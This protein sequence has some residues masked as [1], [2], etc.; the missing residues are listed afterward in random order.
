MKGEGKSKKKKKKEE[1]QARED[2]RANEAK[3]T[4]QVF[5]PC[6]TSERISVEELGILI[7]E[8]LASLTTIP[9]TCMHVC[10][11]VRVHAR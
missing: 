1:Q 5:F 7:V 10:M 3:E 9:C 11:Y 2:E 8:V 6:T 4:R